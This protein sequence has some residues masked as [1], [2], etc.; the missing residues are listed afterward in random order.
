MSEP[1][2]LEH[3]RVDDIPLLVGTMQR[4]QLASLL[5]RHLG[6]HGLHQGLSNGALAM[7][8]LAYIMSGGDHRKST[9][10]DW[11]QRR[12]R[13][14]RKLLG[15]SI[16]PVEFGD[17]RL[18]ILLHRLSRHEAWEGLEAELWAQTVAVYDLEVRGIRLDS[19]T[20]YGY[21]TVRE[22]GLMQFGHSK[23][24]RPDL[25]QL[26]LM[27]AAT[28]GDGQLVALDV[29]TGQSAD[30]GL[31]RPL[32]ARVRR[33]LGRSG[34]LYSGDSKMASLATRADIAG[35]EDHY[36][37]PLPLIGKTPALL[38]GWVEAVVAGGQSVELLRD[39]E[40][41][42]GAGYEFERSL[43]AVV[44]G[45]TVEWR[46]RV[47]VIRLRELARQEAEGL[48]KRLAQAEQKLRA[49]APLVSRGKRYYRNEVSI[50]EAIAK[51][52]QHYR[53]EGLLAV[54][55]E[56]E[57]KSKEGY[58]GPGRGGPDRQKVTQT[59]VRYVVSD[60]QRDEEAIVQKCCRLGWRVQVTNAPAEQMSM[61]EAVIHYRGGW[62]LERDFHLIKDRPLGVSPLYVR[63]E[64]QI[65]GLTRLLSLGLRVLTLIET[66]VRGELAKAHEVL[67][68]LYAGQPERATDRPTAPRMLE[69]FGRAEITL[70]HIQSCGQSLWHITPLSGPLERILTH[71][72]LSKDLYQRLTENSP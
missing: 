4:M 38:E 43:S 58:A 33:S 49:L 54:S 17:D 28:E 15:R 66:R 50:R 59:Q 40:R 27:A 44:E 37:M 69:A 42:L 34:L 47:Q 41:T 8:W 46:E 26:K 13:L 16:R 68:G 20:A 55:L 11:A 62:S 30:E 51:V 19:T 71:L 24:H 39:G 1:L 6:N 67:E 12:R 18:G 2:I 35:H 32:I 56:R 21:H 64:D 14:L 60:V 5:D 70:T 52:E 3:E 22:A 57:E 61:A 23:D 36:L 63:K 10:Q 29:C 65:V 31:Y 53:V 48:D 45:R 25:P 72:G 9:V 7:V